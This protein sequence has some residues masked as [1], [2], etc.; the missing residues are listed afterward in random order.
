[1]VKF[2]E[3]LQSESI[4]YKML[5]LKLAMLLALTSS[6]RSHELMYLNLDY[7]IKHHTSYCFHFGDI[8]KTARE[9]KLRE[10]IELAHFKENKESCV[11]HHIDLYEAKTKPFRSGEGRLLFRVG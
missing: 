7:L 1:M 4:S 5:T 8:T 3:S 9:G 2:L 6:A 10:P 11:C